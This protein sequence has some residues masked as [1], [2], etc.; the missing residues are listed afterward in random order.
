M[1]KAQR[2]RGQAG[3]VLAL[4]LLV[5]LPTF[6]H[7]FV[8]DDPHLIHQS[9]AIRSSGSA[10][11]VFGL[12]YW[13]H[14]HFAKGGTYRPLPEVSLLW[15]YAYR[16]A[17]PRPFHGTNLLLHGLVCV[18]VFL[19][20]KHLLRRAGLAFAA[21]LVFALHPVLV[22][23]AAWAKNVAVLMAV[24]FSLIAWVSYCRALASWPESRSRSWLWATL[25]AGA[26][27]CAAASKEE[28]L[29][30]A[31]V[32]LCAGLVHREDRRGRLL[33][34][35]PTALGVA[36]AVALH[37]L[38]RAGA[39]PHG[40]P[41]PG[42]LGRVGP[43][44][45]AFAEYW[46]ALLL[47]I[48]CCADHHF[49]L[50]GAKTFLRGG[51]ILAASAPFCLLV[52]RGRGKLSVVWLLVGIAPLCYLAAMSERPLA[53]QRAYFALVGASALM[54]AVF[55]WRPTP[56]RRGLFACALVALSVLTVR[57]VFV[58]RSEHS[59]WMDT[60]PK[61][62]GHYRPWLNLAST[63]RASGRISEAKR[64]LH[65]S[66]ERRP[67]YARA[68]NNLGNLCQAQGD[69]QAAVA[70]YRAAVHDG[71]RFADAWNNM[72]TSLAALGRTQEAIDALTEAIRLRPRYRQAH[73]NRGKVYIRL[74]RWAD[75]CADLQ[76]GLGLLPE[77][78]AR[79]RCELGDIARREGRVDEAA[80]HYQ[81]AID[82]DR[83][84]APAWVQMANLHMLARD[85]LAAVGRYS[86]AVGLAP[87]LA[88]A[89]YN[90]ATAL[91]A[92]GLRRPAI[93]QM[94]QAIRLSP[95]LAQRQDW[96]SVTQLRRLIE[97]Q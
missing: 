97:Q 95:E 75:A 7:G 15:S 64:L 27:L 62:P 23:T 94:K 77:T 87:D 78:D 35:V 57:Q 6:W 11:R 84:Y 60:V 76:A 42:G 89:R 22:E 54:V 28:G 69:H 88:E 85:T 58:W 34:L 43:A 71:P 21:G 14:E 70:H 8:W 41:T 44:F 40:S 9:A 20:A 56:A 13:R 1:T 51:V 26:I 29:L 39:A 45:V 30:V 59:L 12:E 4:S 66:I 36:A 72:G 50:G 3:L 37:V 19:A 33:L 91:Q 38:V 83:N 52:W 10:W 5:I 32:M 67:V 82:L 18:L 49:A 80:K 92:L 73:L 46:R 79:T 48:S 81:R 16:G 17:D 93:V 2:E 63:L 55:L 68:R 90:Y 74:Q 53:E 86:I 61:S 31:G 25:A 65:L 24:A 47:P 96:I